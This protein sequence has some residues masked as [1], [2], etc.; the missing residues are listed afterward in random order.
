MSGGHARSDHEMMFGMGLT[1]ACNSVCPLNL[2]FSPH[3]PIS[4][5]SSPPPSQSIFFLNHTHTQT[6]MDTHT[7]TYIH[8]HTYNPQRPVHA[9]ARAQVS[10]YRR[11][12]DEE[13]QQRAAEYTTLFDAFSSIRPAVLEQMPVAQSKA[14]AVVATDLEAEA[15]A[16]G[17]VGTAT[18]PTTA[19]AQQGAL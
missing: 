16:G 5:P 2:S 10:L 9:T 17:N 8:T 11:S 1:F 3:H 15:E 7:R 14:R 19:T 4:F 18:Q 6:Y 13:M 12:I